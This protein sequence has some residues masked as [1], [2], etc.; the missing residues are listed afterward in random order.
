MEAKPSIDSVPPDELSRSDLN[1]YLSVYNYS[2]LRALY[3]P[4]FE[5]QKAP[6]DHSTGAFYWS[7]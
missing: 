2:V 3:L 4:A 7:R 1:S 5:Q 6:A